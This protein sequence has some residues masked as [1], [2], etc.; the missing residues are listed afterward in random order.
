MAQSGQQKF[1]HEAG[2]AVRQ[3]TA[4]KTSAATQLRW[5]RE[6]AKELNEKGKAENMLPKEPM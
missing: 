4:R 2:K 6:N 1:L 3:G 5:A